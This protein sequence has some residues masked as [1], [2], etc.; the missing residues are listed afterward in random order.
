M[1]PETFLCSNCGE[2]MVPAEAVLQRGLLNAL[3]FGFGSSR[4]DIRPQ[5]GRRWSTFMTPARA[6]E[7][8]YCTRCGALFIAPSLKH[9]RK[10]LGLE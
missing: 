8:A 9:H 4:L 1:K 7:A 2:S 6:S 10:D 3:A 5:S